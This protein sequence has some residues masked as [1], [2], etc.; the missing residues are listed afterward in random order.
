M[1]Q[2]VPI[3]FLCAVVFALAWNASGR[4]GC[5]VLALGWLVYP[6]YEHFMYTRVHCTGECNIRVDPLRIYPAL[7][8][9]S[10]WVAVAAAV[11][12]IQQAA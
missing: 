6:V 2:P 8:I 4:R 5:L 1:F 12:S 3:A 9:G 7:L 11:R 10:I